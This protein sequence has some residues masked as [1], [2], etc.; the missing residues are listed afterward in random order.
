MLVVGQQKIEVVSLG[1]VILLI[2]LATAAALAWPALNPWAF[3]IPTGAALALFW[4][5]RWEITA[6]IGRAHV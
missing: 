5:A 2:A 4:A 3:L 1:A 6:Q